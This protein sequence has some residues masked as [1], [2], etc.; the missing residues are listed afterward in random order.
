M[1]NK[2]PTTIKG[3]AQRY[4]RSMNLQLSEEKYTRDYRRYV[5]K[6]GG[7]GSKFHMAVGIV[8]SILLEERN[9]SR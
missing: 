9:G 2:E 7:G 1:E 3:H 4:A 6:F 8:D 5:R